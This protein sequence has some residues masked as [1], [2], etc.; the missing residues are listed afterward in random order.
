MPERDYLQHDEAFQMTKRAL[1]ESSVKYIQEYLREHFTPNCDREIGYYN[2]Y[3]GTYEYEASFDGTFEEFIAYVGTLKDR[4]DS[5]HGNSAF[6]EPI[7]MK[8]YER[9]EDR[10]A[11]Y[12]NQETD[13]DYNELE[14]A[15]DGYTLTWWEMIG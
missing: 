10:L 14:I 9:T 4:F 8:A 2:T 5:Y 3:N 15:Y 11:E 7:I 1:Y 12:N 13:T 6:P